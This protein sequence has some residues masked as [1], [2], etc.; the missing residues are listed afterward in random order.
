MKKSI[1]IL[2]LFSLVIS[3]C[4]CQQLSEIAYEQSTEN[5]KEKVE[6][7]AELKKDTDPAIKMLISIDGITGITPPSKKFIILPPEG[8]AADILFEKV[9]AELTNVLEKQ[10]YKR[11]RKDLA[12]TI[13]VLAYSSSNREGQIAIAAYD[14]KT[15]RENRN[16]E[17]AKYKLMGKTLIYYISGEEQDFKIVYPSVLKQAGPYLL[18][19]VVPTKYFKE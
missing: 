8:K 12:E 10:G 19:D 2:F 16:T 11:V 14:A 4:G 5:L 7:D 9:A 1:T 17:N 15:A 3:V 13:I 6:Q 18:K